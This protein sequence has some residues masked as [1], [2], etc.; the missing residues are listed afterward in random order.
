MIRHVIRQERRGGYWMLRDQGRVVPLGPSA[1]RWLAASIDAESAPVEDHMERAAWDEDPTLYALIGQQGLT[2]KAARSTIR[3][4][5]SPVPQTQ[6]PRDAVAAPKRIYFEM[7]RRCNL[8]C[9]SC[10]N[11]SRLP[12]D[13]EMGLDQV[14]DVNRQAWDLGVFEMRYTGGECTTLPWFP[15]VIEDACRKGFYISVGTNG[16]WSETALEWLPRSG[17]DWLILSLDGDRDSND[18]IRGRGTYDKVLR[19][20]RIAV[21][22]SVRTRINMVVAR[23]NRD[24]IEAVARVAVDHGVESLNLIPLR[25]YGRSLRELAHA[26]FDQQ[27]FYGFIREINRLRRQFPGL[28]FATTID[29]LAPQ[30]RTSHDPVVEKKTTCAA[31]VEACVVGPQG[32]V[33]GCSYSPASFPD[34]EDHEGRR[35]FVA[36]NLRREPLGRI[37]RDSSRWAVFRDLNRYKH[38]KCLTCGHHKVRCSGSCPIMA[39]HELGQNAGTTKRGEDISKVCDP[40]CFADLLIDARAEVD[41]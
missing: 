19:T 32:D 1:Y 29:L 21:E 26:M 27:D 39:W 30:A 2:R 34:S 3:L 14:L 17:I 23:H 12:L 37:W 4:V 11:A 24:S 25:P 31:G 36:G 41:A 15:R 6:L 8:A 5:P 40:Y 38:P 20:L 22:N 28:C 10:F 9:R 13:D 35:V 18:Q 7:T 16:I 33:Y